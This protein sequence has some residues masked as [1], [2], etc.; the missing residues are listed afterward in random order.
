MRKNEPVTDREVELSTE[1][2]IV[3]VTDPRGMILSASP[4][5]VRISG[6]TEA[7]LMGQPQNLVRHP[8][9]PPEAFASLW[10]T[11]QK[12]RSWI[13][14]V[15]NRTKR[16]DFYWVKAD[17]SPVYEGSRLIGYRSV[18]T[19]PTREEVERASKLYAD[20]NA[21][22]IKNPFHESRF[23]AALANLS[24]RTR[25]IAGMVA[26]VGSVLLLAGLSWSAV[27]R[28]SRL[29]SDLG[30][31]RQQVVADVHL[32][33]IGSALAST[34]KSAIISAKPQESKADIEKAIS[35]GRAALAAARSSGVSE[36]EL[37]RVTTSFEAMAALTQQE[38]LPRFEKNGGRVDAE[39]QA[40]E[41]RLA[42][43]ERE[44]HDA[45]DQATA[46]V[47]ARSEQGA[48]SF[49]RDVTALEVSFAVFAVVAVLLQVLLLGAGL[50]RPLSRKLATAT[51]AA[52]RIA[53]GDLGTTFAVQ[54]DDEMGI[55]IDRLASVQSSLKAMMSDARQLSRA[56]VEGQLSVRA[57]PTKHQGEYRRIIEGVNSTL[58]SVI[59]P[60]TAAANVE[61]IAAGRL[62]EPITDEWRGDFNR[63]KENLNTATASVKALVTDAAMLADAG[64]AGRLEVRADGSR[65]QG[66]FKRIVEGVNATLDSIIG[67]VNATM[68]VLGAMGQGDLTRRVETPYRGQLETLRVAV[69]STSEKLQTTISEVVATAAQLAAAAE[70]VR[71]TSQSLASAA[72]EQASSVEETS[73]SVS[74]MAASITQNAES[75]KLT[76]GRAEKAAREASEGGSAVRQTVEAMKQIAVR[77]GIIDDIAYQTNM[78]ALNAAIEAARAGAHGKGFAVVAAEVRKLAERSQVAAQEIGTL[79]GGSVKDAERAGS[80]IGEVVP[81][82]TQ[83]SELVQEIAAASQEQSTGVGQI[84]AAMNQMNK[85]TQ[86]N[87]AASE[88]LSAT[89]EKMAAAT[90]RLEAVIGFFSNGGKASRPAQA[91]SVVD[92]VALGKPVKVAAADDRFV[93]FS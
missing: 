60:L 19:R 16:G 36:A 41:R 43:L 8:D 63:L 6:F 81:A 65:H 82:I 23:S 79:A 73:S 89:S 37:A 42:V 20:I 62:P 5:F 74:Q 39:V 66:D 49:A 7:E 46:L 26:A 10:Q 44:V 2:V 11:I 78:L 14:F 38:L 25:I 59:R 72:T 17:V 58:D 85:T 61:Q 71:A 54:H 87:A 93:P 33:Q 83:T 28:L 27:E 24:V 47:Q 13:G 4:D 57:D 88:E 22:R 84:N 34:V 69:N 91:P 12:G 3:S 67:P 31:A 86:Q 90:A 50:L 52:N 15:K 53:A 32:S 75:A 21:R 40:M 29:E 55:L 70:Q 9:M 51:D 48:R 76:S 45:A 92:A 64:V 18:R 56:A 80:L 68:T 30:A 35:A 77:I 1:D